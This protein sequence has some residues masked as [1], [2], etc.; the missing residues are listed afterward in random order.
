MFFRGGTACCAITI[1]K[2]GV[3]VLI[4]VQDME[5]VVNAWLHTV[6]AESFQL[7][8]FLQKLKLHMIEV[9]KL[10]SGTGKINSHE[11]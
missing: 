1:R 11:Q 5:N 3:L 2:T 6:F 4:A 9:T 8:F 10:W 7:A